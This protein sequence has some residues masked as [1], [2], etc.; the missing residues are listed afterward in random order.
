[1]RPGCVRIEN[2][3][4][5]TAFVK[6][7]V[8]HIRSDLDRKFRKALKEAVAQDGG[9]SARDLV[10]RALDHGP[11]RGGAIETIHHFGSE[12]PVKLVLTAEIVDGIE[13]AMP[14]FKMELTGFANDLTM[15]RGFVAWAEFKAGQGRVISGVKQAFD[16]A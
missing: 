4:G 14:G 10:T 11:R 12:L 2:A 16:Q 15:V 9:K 8:A 7:Q 6:D 1:M 13:I 3:Q 5:A